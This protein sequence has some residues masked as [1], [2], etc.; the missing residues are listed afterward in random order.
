MKKTSILLAFVLALAA[1]PRFCGPP[2]AYKARRIWT[3]SG[4]PIDNGVLVV[5]DGKIVAV[6]REIKVTVPEDAEIHDSVRQ[7]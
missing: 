7:C 5:H 2:H 1:A 3:G 6:G 4:L